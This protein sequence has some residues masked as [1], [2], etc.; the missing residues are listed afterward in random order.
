MLSP[1]IFSLYGI[2]DQIFGSPCTFVWCFINKCNAIQYLMCFLALNWFKFAPLGT[3][4]NLLK[5]PERAFVHWN[6]GRWCCSH[7]NRQQGNWY[8]G[9]SRRTGTPL[10]Q[11]PFQDLP[12][13]FC[14]NS[15]HVCLLYLFPVQHTE[16]IIWRTCCWNVRGSQGGSLETN[17]QRPGMQFAEIKVGLYLAHPSSSFWETRSVKMI[18]NESHSWEIIQFYYF[19]FGFTIFVKLVG[20]VI[21]VSV[22]HYLHHSIHR[23]FG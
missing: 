17:K 3:E 10:N 21:W 22:D 4:C 13:F 9:P 2:F 23:I 8:S 18:D 11:Q 16:D 1:L 7:I 20:L 19:L 5:A 6:W 15:R 12:L 14:F